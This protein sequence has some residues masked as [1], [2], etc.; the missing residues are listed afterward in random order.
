MMT[1]RHTPE[2][3]AP[4]PERLH[5]LE[6]PLCDVPAM[7]G[8]YGP[9][10]YSLATFYPKKIQSFHEW[11]VRFQMSIQNGSVEDVLS[12]LRCGLFKSTHSHTFSDRDYTHL[13]PVKFFLYLSDGW[14]DRYISDEWN[15]HGNTL[16]YDAFDG[17]GDIEIGLIRQR[18]AARAFDAFALHVFQKEAALTRSMEENGWLTRSLWI[19]GLLELM[20]RFFVPYKASCSVYRRI[21]N[22]PDRF[23]RGV[24]PHTVDLLELFL[25]IL[26]TQ[27]WGTYGNR[28]HDSGNAQEK[29][30]CN[31]ARIWS[32]DIIGYFGWW[33]LLRA[34]GIKLSREHLSIIRKMALQNQIWLSH[35]SNFVNVRSL[36]E[37]VLL[38]SGAALFLI[39]YDAIQKARKYQE[40]EQALCW[41]QKE[42]NQNKKRM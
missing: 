4:N 9:A 41:E 28:V 36:D 38:G 39:E 14:C 8:L 29:A 5:R 20:I 31:S 22:I 21:R 26:V 32:L 27:I 30:L 35:Q 12:L 2:C 15:D 18:I 3:S 16:H 37:A 23:E 6:H 25:K 33:N 40:D 34:E 17:E 19:G 13:E 24:K 11:L 7:L 10:A 1:Q 42:R